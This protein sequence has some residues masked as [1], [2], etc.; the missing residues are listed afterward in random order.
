M[1]PYALP[2]AETR[3][4]LS[5]LVRGL[6]PRRADFSKKFGAYLGADN[7][8]LAGNARSLLYLLL[9]A[10]QN[11]AGAGSAKEVLIPGYTCYS[12]AAAVVKAGLKV[13][14]YDLDP[15]TF[16]PDFE[17]VR[18]KINSATLA[19]IGQHLLGV[20]ADIKELAEI[21][22][23]HG[24]CC[25]E[26]SSQHLGAGQFGPG[27]GMIADYA[28]FSFGR[29]KPLPL[30]SGGALVAKEQEILFQVNQQ[31]KT[32]PAHSANRLLP[33]AVQILSWPRLYWI[34]ERLPLGLGSTHYDPGFS[35]STMAVFYQ[36]LANDA[37]AGLDRLTQHRAKLSRIYQQQFSDS[38]NGVSSC[39]RYPLLVG[40]QGEF[41]R[42]F[43]LGVRRLYPL[44]LCDLP[45]LNASL[46]IRGKPVLGA[47]EIAAQLVT[48]PTHLAANTKTARKIAYESIKIFREIKIISV[49]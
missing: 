43:S 16:Q 23:Q 6:L 48:L 18:R 10:L 42:I 37:L 5:A 12:V 35:V 33:Y 8:I 44:A 28:I 34:L 24:V 22:H 32:C 7:C 27:K 38:E 45:G 29:G 9:R 40:N 39:V 21:A 41:L 1:I 47:R 31:L 11:Q 30:G 4:P 46:V 13:A 15:H 26:D 14:L 49:R 17:D 25:I 36:R 20:K 19:V 2:P 3:L